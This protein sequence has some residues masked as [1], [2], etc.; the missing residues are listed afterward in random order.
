MK[1]ITRGHLK[2][3][4]DSVR[5]TKWR[6][7]WTMLG[8][9]IGVASVITVVGI[10]DG[11]KQQVNSQLHH[12]G[13]NVILI[14]PSAINGN[15]N[16]PLSMITGFDVSGTLSAHDDQVVS[17][18]PGVTNSAPLS[19]I[20]AKVSGDQSTYDQSKPHDLA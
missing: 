6:N 18:V 12:A 10:G 14:K 19:A 16:S 15:G 9:I 1:S 4:I 17:S 7:F 11:I 2:A 8:V 13:S 5:N 3:G 20:S